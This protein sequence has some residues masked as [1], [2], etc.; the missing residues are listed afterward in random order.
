MARQFSFLLLGSLLGAA[1]A[2]DS[3][4]PEAAPSTFAISLSATDAAVVLALVNYPGASQ[5]VL[6][7][8]AGLDARAAQ[9]IAEHRAGA[10][11][12]FPSGDDDLF[13]DIAELDAVPYVGDVAFQKLQS[14]AQ[15]HP[16]PAA[17]SVEGV[18]FL[19]WE[20]ET[21]IWGVN[22]VEIDVLDGMLDGRAAR[23]LF[24]ARPFAS[25]TEMGRI[26]YVG[27][28]ALDRLRREAPVWWT[29]RQSGG[30]GGSA[31]S[32][33]GT[34]DGVVFDEATARIALEI[35]N[36]DS[37][38][39]MVAHGVYAA[40][41]A[42]IV[43]NRPFQSLA[44]VAAVSGVG[45]STMRGLHDYA[46]SGTW[47]GMPG[48]PEEPPPDGGLT[49]PDPNCVL[50]LSYRDIFT[51]GGT[52]IVARRVIDPATDTNAMQRSQVIAAVKSAYDSVTT[53]W[54]ALDVV[55]ENRV[56]QIEIWD[57]SN[58]RAYTA[59]EFGA[60]DNSYGL[61]FAYATTTVAA[62]IND[63]DLYSCT[64]MWGNEMRPCERTEDCADGLTCF[65][66]SEAVSTGR[67][68]NLGAAEHV[69]EGTD[70][71]LEAGCPGGSGLVCAGALTSGAGICVPA[72]MRNHFEAGYDS[73]P[74]PDGA[75]AGIALT[76]PVYGLATVDTDVQ[77]DLTISHPRISDLRV[78]LTNP[79]TAE[80]LVIDAAGMTGP[81][82]ALRNHVVRGFSGDEQVNGEWILRVVDRTGGSTGTIDRFAL[83]I[84]SRWD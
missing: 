60:G 11:G 21:V 47:T 16:A 9:H 49:P 51:N 45:A 48:E 53:F 26:A 41:A 39:S 57:A 20:S 33:A 83:T 56:N 23:N 15:A 46:T 44:G 84:T 24:A 17:E 30:G 14:Y 61:V 32:L 19:G 77:I 8:A 59:Y 36:Q 31:P 4:D 62:R 50:G 6:D 73:T 22:S 35:A 28:A 25:V 5:A 43:G 72:W 69:A 34:F 27:T 79:A 71:T 12:A 76:M 7:D 80:V 70:C 78:T 29:A 67:C 10:D 52:I 55:D 38:E 18:L 3:V 81:E 13:E 2:A 42:A 65:G 66:S 40:G 63:G 82:I 54:H 75:A 58:R 74:I 64:A 1:C 68:M 37:R